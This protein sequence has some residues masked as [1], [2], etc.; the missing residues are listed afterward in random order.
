MAKTILKSVFCVF[1]SVTLLFSLAGC[2]G[3]TELTQ[4]NVTQTMSVVETALKE[5]DKKKLEKYVDS[6]TLGYILKLSD[7]DDQYSELGKAIFENLTIEIED[8]DLDA[9]TITVTVLNKD[10]YLVAADFTTRLLNEHNKIQLL[11][12]LSD[13]EFLN[14]SLATLIEGIDSSEMRTEPST[15]TLTIAQGKRNLVIGFDDA[16]ENAVSGGA[17]GAIKNIVK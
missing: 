6:E 5:F 1:L 9:K 12:M 17:L 10:L 14:S 8:I 7:G 13:E 11:N 15:V 16:A 2:S 4:E 3:N